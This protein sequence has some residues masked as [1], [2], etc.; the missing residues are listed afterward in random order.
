MYIIS[1][2][3]MVSPNLIHGHIPFESDY[4]FLCVKNIHSFVVHTF[5]EI[6]LTALIWFCT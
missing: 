6:C 3:Q 1:L 2:V 5:L 4:I